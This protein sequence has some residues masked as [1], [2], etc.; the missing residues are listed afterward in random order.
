MWLPLPHAHEFLAKLVCFDRKFGFEKI[1]FVAAE[2]PLQGRAAIR[3]LEEVANDDLK[4]TDLR[5][6]A[7]IGEKMTWFTEG[8]W[9][10]AGSWKKAVPR[11]VR[12][13]GFVAQSLSVSSPSR[14]I[15]SIDRAGAELASLR[16]LLI[17]QSDRAAP[18]LLSRANDWAALLEGAKVRLAAL[19]IESQ[20]IPQVFRFGTPVREDEAYVFVGRQGLVREL[21]AVLL[22]VTQPPAI[23][24]HGARRMGKSSILCQLPRLL[25]PEF[26]P[27][28]MDCQNPATPGECGGVSA[29]LGAHHHRWAV[30]SGSGGGRA[31]PPLFSRRPVWSDE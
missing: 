27:C 24:M 28:I 21:E 19:A 17:V 22:G 10:L 31:G 20:E 3:A 25:G 15:E 26:A 11:F 30:S 14:Q 2:R 4:V 6:I 18:R 29:D 23:L 9:D 13:A 1:A 5:S 7:E 8:E 12:V 16:S